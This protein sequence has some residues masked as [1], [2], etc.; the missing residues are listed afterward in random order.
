MIRTEIS[1]DPT[2]YPAS[3]INCIHSTGK[4]S[5]FATN[6]FFYCACAVKHGL[7]SESMLR[8]A[9][10]RVSFMI[11]VC[12]LLA[13]GVI[14][15]RQREIRPLDAEIFEDNSTMSRSR[16]WDFTWVGEQVPFFWAKASYSGITF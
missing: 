7:L 16:C 15:V 1:S 4:A 6:V 5:I 11:L 9:Q 3:E 2:L 12:S 13:G 10:I 8:Q 14:G